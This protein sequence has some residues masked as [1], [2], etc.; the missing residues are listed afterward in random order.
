MK[1]SLLI[2]LLCLMGCGKEKC[3]EYIY[4]GCVHFSPITINGVEV[5]AGQTV[6][7]NSYETMKMCD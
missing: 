1:Y 5:E 6:C 4:Q 3:I 2:L 7:P